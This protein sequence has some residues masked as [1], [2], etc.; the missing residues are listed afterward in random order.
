MPVP[1]AMQISTALVTLIGLVLLA[2]GLG[3]IK[4]EAVETIVFATVLIAIGG[5]GFMKGLK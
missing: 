1:V 3:Y 5:L 4:C 2:C